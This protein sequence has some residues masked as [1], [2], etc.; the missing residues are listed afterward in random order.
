ML[1]DVAPTID[2][3]DG[4]L[5]GRERLHILSLLAGRTRHPARRH[6]VGEP[7]AERGT[8]VLVAGV[9]RQDTGGIR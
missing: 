4:R 9:Y 2:Y 3:A 7:G 1:N 6:L 5:I 8:T